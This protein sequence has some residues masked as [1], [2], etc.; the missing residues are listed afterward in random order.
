MLKRIALALGL[1]VWASCQTPTPTP[2]WQY[3]AFIDAAYLLDFN[4]P[5]N[6][7]FRSRGTA[8]K[9][10]QPI[11]NM[12]GAYVRKSP[13]EASRW[14]LEATAQGGQDSRVFG[15]SATAPNLPG[16]TGLRHWGPTNVS[17]LAPI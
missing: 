8:Y 17:Y 4:H 2:T 11:L 1:C 13:S 6:D 12:A 14:G 16:S 5:E 10:D 9:V 3:G 7:F 15:F